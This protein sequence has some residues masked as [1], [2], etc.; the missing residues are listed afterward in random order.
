MINSNENI[1]SELSKYIDTAYIPDFLGGPC[2]FDVIFFLF[3]K[4]CIKNYSIYKYFLNIK[5]LD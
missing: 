5:I 2:K 3:L 4:I 1:I